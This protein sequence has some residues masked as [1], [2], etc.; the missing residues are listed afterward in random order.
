MLAEG[1]CQGG[2][3]DVNSAWFVFRRST[4]DRMGDGEGGAVTV[5]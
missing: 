5:A 3:D 1:L 4:K 2:I